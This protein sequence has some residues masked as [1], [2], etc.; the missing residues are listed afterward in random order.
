MVALR[1]YESKTAGIHRWLN[2]QPPVYRAE[3]DS[4]LELLQATTNLRWIEWV[5]PLRGKCKGL[6]EI[7]IDFD[8]DESDTKIHFRILGY[9]TRNGEFVLLFPF[10]KFGGPEYGPACRSAFGRMRGVERDGQRAQP[11]RFP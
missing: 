10:R 9:Q 8:D 5:K 7:K 2:I 11:C 1:C 4:V 3:I 6:T